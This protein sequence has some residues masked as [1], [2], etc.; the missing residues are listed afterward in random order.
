MT[1]LRHLAALLLAIAGSSALAQAT[2]VATLSARLTEA[3][4]ELQA[5][6]DA[7]VDARTTDDRAALRDR[8]KAVQAI[9]TDAARVL[10]PQMA[11]VQARVVELGAVT[12]G[13]VETPDIRAQRA[14]LAR[15]Q[16]QLDSTI[17]RARLI[18]VEAKQEIDDIAAADAQQIGQRLS[19]RTASPL[20]PALWSGVVEHLP[21]DTGRID[22][23]MRTGATQFAHRFDRRSGTAILIALLAALVLLIPVRGALHRVG[24]RYAANQAPG[25]RL[26]RSAFA[27]W[28]VVVGTALP[29][30]AALVVVQA[31]RWSDVLTKAWSEFGSAFVGVTFVSAFVSALGGA[32][33]LRGQSSWRLLPIGDGAAH[34]LRPY[35]WAAAALAFFGQ[36]LIATNQLVGASVPATTLADALI[37]LLHLILIGTA[38]VTLGRLR[39]AALPDPEKPARNSM[40]AIVSML[41]WLMLAAAFVGGLIGYVN[42]ALQLGQWMVWI[43]IVGA[44]LYLMMTFTDD[45]CRTLLSSSNRIGRSA[46]SGF[47]VGNRT[48][49]QIGVL[50]SAFLRLMLI[51]LAIGAVMAPFG[52]GVGSL[53]DMAGTLANG[54]TVGQVTISPGA[55]LR[56]MLVLVVALAAMRGLQHWLVNSYLP[57]TALDAGARNSIVMIARYTGIAAAVLWAL[58]AL[59]IGMER[60]AVV[61]GAL[62]VGIGFGLQAITQNFVSGLI[63]LAER[64]VKIGDL[65]RIGNLE[66]DVK[67]I[68]VRST[69]IEVADRSTLIVPNSELITKTIQNLTLAAPIGRIQLQF[70][71]PLE[72]DLDAVRAMLFA[73]FAGDDRVLVEPEPKVFI[74]SIEGTRAKF[75]CFAYVASPRDTYPVRSDLLFTLLRQF[76]AAGIDLAASTQKMELIGAAPPIEPPDQRKTATDPA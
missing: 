21:R 6:D 62:S 72:S 30:I 19:E 46:N 59:G 49:D 5:V 67:R 68:S 34:T 9:A 7:A 11:L 12:P 71:V 29:G 36:M 54:V 55:V 20:S 23:F 73:A 76:R 66:G 41:I 26:R 32:L 61:L 25:G 45:A 63:L 31:L 60:L 8:A 70:A 14:L 52:A 27:L 16:S 15:S 74:D 57:T 28:L 2:D 35:S 53:F 17:K 24:R 33:L 3:S 22:R 38:L 50:M 58:A 13:V 69:E 48:V 43:A 39:A 10:T 18:A 37:A 65:V 64:P 51:L 44:T 1:V 47:G 42:F 4:R 75:N 40:L 56:A